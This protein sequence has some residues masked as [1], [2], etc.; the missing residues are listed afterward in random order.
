MIRRS[1]TQVLHPAEA[2][3]QSVQ[4]QA[5]SLPKQALRG[6]PEVVRV[7]A[8]PL[9][10]G[11]R[12]SRRLELELRL[13]VPGGFGTMNVSGPVSDWSFPP[14]AFQVGQ[15]T[16]GDG[17]R[18]LWQL[19]CALHR[20]LHAAGHMPISSSSLVAHAAV[21]WL[22]CH[23]NQQLACLQGDQ[24]GKPWRAVRFAG[25]NASVWPM[26]FEL[27]GPG[28]LHLDVSAGYIAEHVAHMQPLAARFPYWTSVKP[29]LAFQSHW[30]F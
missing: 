17:C 10:V 13:P 29:I 8:A 14:E 20:Q 4:L 30:D 9:I 2:L 23:W 21:A 25:N 11:P 7:K 19:F 1:V 26:W 24:A 16:A 3:L 22:A 12:G 15:Q 27:Q 18:P 5:P 28:K 6:L